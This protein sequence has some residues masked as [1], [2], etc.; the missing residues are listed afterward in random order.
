MPDKN[1]G[2]KIIVI[3]ETMREGMQF[4]G[5]VFS[6]EQR[7]IMLEFQEALGIDICQIGYPSAHPMEAKIVT[8]VAA[9]AKKN[10][11]RIRTAAL[12]RAFVPDAKILRETAIDD[13][14]F[15]LQVK[16][17]ITP[18][19][20]NR[21]F[22]DLE[23]TIGIV[24][25]GRPGAMISIAMLDIGKTDPG[26]LERCVKFLSQNLKIDI[27]SLPDTSGIMAPNQ[28]YDRI[29]KLAELPIK[30]QISIHC[31]NDMGMASANSIMGI[32]AGASVL[33]VS[34]LGIGERNGIGDLFTIAKLLKTQGVDLGVDTDNLSLFRK[35]YEYLDAIVR[36][37]TGHGLIQY[38][39]P[40]FG[41]AIG[42]HVA[43]TH[44]KGKFGTPGEEK[45]YLNLLCGRH[46]VQKYLEINKIP[47]DD[48]WL[49]DITATIKTRSIS[50]GRRLTKDEI[51][52]IAIAK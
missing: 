51:K 31:H 9:H 47:Y 22:Q 20:L 12:G 36:E 23:T 7:I 10:N 21:L 11:F 4:Q 50:Q 19:A 40:A 46:L 42:T 30:A 29:R 17:A 5:L 13:P 25:N 28:V 45:F 26:L 44:A 18:T 24:R 38:N 37:Q 2:K 48:K 39:T 1:L 8:Q 32:M 43:G 41:E 49:P 33:E 35:Y 3:D 34:A 27:L 6:L 52:A 14:N 15:H 16:N